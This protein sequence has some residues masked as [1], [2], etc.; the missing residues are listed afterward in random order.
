ME[1]PSN[2]E[3]ELKLTEIAICSITSP[4]KLSCQSGGNHSLTYTVSID[5]LP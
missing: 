1:N 3:I 4:A 2:T 5:Q